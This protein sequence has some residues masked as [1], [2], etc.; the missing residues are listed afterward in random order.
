MGVMRFLIQPA[1]RVATWPEAHLAY[2]SG[3]D[4]SVH[5]TR[6][7]VEGAM[8]ICRRHISETGKLHVP[9]PVEGFGRPV[10][11]TASLPE[12]QTPYLLPLELARGKIV[13]LRN[14]LATWEAA[15]MQIPPEYLSLHAETHTLF[16]K[17]VGKQDN[18]VECARFSDLALQKAFQA[19]E[20]LTQAYGQQSLALRHRRY[21]QIP[22][23][24][25]CYLP[26]EVEGPW[27]A[28]YLEAFNS[29]AVSV[30]W[31]N[32]EPVEGEYHWELFDAQV[33]WCEDHRLVVRGGPLLDLAHALGKRHLESAEFCVRF[34]GDRDIPLPGP[35]AHLG[36]G[37]PRQQRR[38]D[39]DFRR[40]PAR[41]RRQ[42]S[43]NRKA[44]R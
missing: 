41:T 30:K 8:L 13:Q 3:F 18:E 23:L 33:D 29:G 17:A 40:K 43:G 12:R 37:C 11:S 24:V 35:R 1:S 22:T 31:R 38:R 25:G 7:E 42:S 44:R 39:G 6:V 32:I 26:H 4:Q 28:P 10:I 19:A 34:C 9:W 16:A 36:S 14:Q 20:F 15:G 2:L 21:A 5:S 27:Q